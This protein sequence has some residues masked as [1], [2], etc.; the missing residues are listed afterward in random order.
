ML[1]IEKL[2]EEKIYMMKDDMKKI[3]A[4]HSSF[5]LSKHTFTIIKE[6]EDSDN[7]II[8]SLSGN[9]TMTVSRKELI[10]VQI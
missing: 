9:E 4:L 1:N 6:D 10:L 2:K 8:Q 7:V 5:I 3:V